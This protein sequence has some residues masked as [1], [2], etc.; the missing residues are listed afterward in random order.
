MEI[1]HDGGEAMR[2]NKIRKIAED[3]RA[4]ANLRVCF[5]DMNVNCGECLKC[6]RTMIPLRL[7]RATTVPFPPL[8]PNKAIR[9]MR[10]A[11]A[12]EKSFFRDNLDLALQSGY[13]GLRNALRSCMRRYERLELVRD[14]DRLILR[15]L[16][17]RIHLA[18][19]GPGFRRT[20]TTPRKD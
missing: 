1:I 12:I 15:G 2:V 16:F 3:A 7:L 4:L 14:V 6:L 13:S 11:G 19:A 17:K 20:N 18:K 8:P 9:K 10:I 5:N